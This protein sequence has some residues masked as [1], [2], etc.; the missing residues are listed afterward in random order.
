MDPKT[1]FE[2]SYFPGCSLATSAQEANQSLKRAC[3]ASGLHLI[4]LDD[5]NCCGTSS[6]HA[7]DHDLALSLAARNLAMAPAD[8]PLMVMCPACYKN[9]AGA[10]LKLMEDQERR[11]D[12]ERRWGGRIAPNLR[13]VTFLE[14]VHFLRRLA[15]MG[16]VRL[17]RP[18]KE[19]GGLAGLKVAPYYGCASMLPPKLRSAS[20]RPGLM[21]DLLSLL[22]AEPLR[23]ALPNRCCG[24]FLTAA[25]PD[26][27]TPLVNDIMQA[28]LDVGAECLVTACA[29]CQLNIEVRCDLDHKLPILHFSEAM[30]L[31]LGVKEP[32]AWFKRHLIDPRPALRDRQLIA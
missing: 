29:M 18:G 22:G 28:A 1:F 6:A 11:V 32:E 16:A 7:L 19:M 13:I 10:H 23:W 31:A 25:R 21:A 14:L 27:T 9:L 2:V 8:R 17:P 24:T 20:F 26:I 3:R 12:E 30:A 5:W 4:E 15:E